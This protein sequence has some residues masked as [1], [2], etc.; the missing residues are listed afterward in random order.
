MKD[1]GTLEVGD[2]VISQ[3]RVCRVGVVNESR[4]RVDPITPALRGRNDF[5]SWD[6]A[7]RALVDPADDYEFDPADTDR[8][9]A[10]LEKAEFQ[11]I[12]DEERRLIV[13]NRRIERAEAEYVAA[14]HNTPAHSAEFESEDT[15]MAVAGVPVSS[16]AQTL[17]AKN[18]ARLAAL[19][20]QKAAAKAAKGKAAATPGA[21][22][23]AAK[24][25]R[26]PKAPKELKA[27]FCGCGDTTGGTF[28][29]GHD[30]RFKGWLLK[31]E[32]GDEKKENLLL[33]AIIAKF[34][35]VPSGMEGKAGKGQRP[36]M[37]YKGEPHSGYARPEDV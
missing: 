19:Q 16:P 22:G 21:N 14:L 28:V 31:I 4:A 6:I 37:N 34:K 32:K 5:D 36:T 18:A 7:P 35:W 11:E 12:L 8:L 26:E 1:D 24:A 10:L 17:K 27:C 9:I 25:P 20:E 29:P 30:A 13:E 33:P 2:L 23:K 15:T 3:Q